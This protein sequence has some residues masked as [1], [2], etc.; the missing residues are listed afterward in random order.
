MRRHTDTNGRSLQDDRAAFVADPDLG[1]QLTEE[2]GA[3]LA[4]DGVPAADE[5][6]TTHVLLG[7]APVPITVEKSGT[8]QAAG[9]VTTAEDRPIDD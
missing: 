6:V 2:P 9:S 7:G 5:A 4:E 8:A 1:A 3:P